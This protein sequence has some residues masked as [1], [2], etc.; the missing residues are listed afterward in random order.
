M[1]EPVAV[2]PLWWRA[3]PWPITKSQND[4]RGSDCRVG[5]VFPAGKPAGASPGYRQARRGKAVPNRAS[6]GVMPGELPTK[7]K[8]GDEHA[9]LCVRRYRKKSALVRRAPRY[10]PA[11]TCG[12]QR[13]TLGRGQL[14]SVA[15]TLLGLLRN[16]K[17]RSNKPTKLNGI[18]RSSLGNIRGERKALASTEVTARRFC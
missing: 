18:Q 7:G 15:I 3:G 11:S 16:V 5:V 4:D 12:K 6:L 14:F 9:S 13:E 2:P 17:S 1:Q 10:S 8:T